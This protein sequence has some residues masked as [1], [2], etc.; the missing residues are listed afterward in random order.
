MRK[1]AERG[2]EDCEGMEYGVGRSDMGERNAGKETRIKN[3]ESMS[4]GRDCQLAYH[5]HCNMA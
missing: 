2:E 3:E 1:M 4:M 5:G